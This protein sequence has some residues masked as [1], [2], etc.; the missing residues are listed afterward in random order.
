[1][2]ERLARARAAPSI[3]KPPDCAHTTVEDSVL[4]NLREA[5]GH[6]LLPRRHTVMLAAIVMTLAVRPLLGDA[7]NGLV[8]F[9]IAMLTLMRVSLYTIQIDE[10]IDERKILQA[11][12]RRRSIIGWGL[13]VPAIADRLVV[14]FAPSHSLYLAGSIIWFLL[15]AFITWNELRG[16]LRQKRITRKTISLSISIYLMIGLTWGLFYIVLYEAQPHAFS[17]G[18]FGTPNSGTP[19]EQ[20]VIPVLLYFSLTTLSTIGFGDIL[21]VTLQARYAA[22][23]EG[24]SGQFY[25][26]ILVARLVGIYM[27][28]TASRD[29]E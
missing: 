25:L 14:I 7:G 11:K 22:V 19:T 8:V 15:F 29:A 1:V 23:A 27:S 18:S 9:S 4:G 6:Y 16:V 13:A 20:Q 17:L 12:R 26:A 5:I 24:I 2:R 28:Q 3:A 10:L 21:P